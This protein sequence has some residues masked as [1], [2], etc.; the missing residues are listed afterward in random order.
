[1]PERTTS[2]A[3]LKKYTDPRALLRS[4]IIENKISIVDEKIF[5]NNDTYSFFVT[6]EENIDYTS[7]I[8]YKY[9][10]IG[11]RT[12]LGVYFCDR[13][14][15]GICV[16]KLHKNTDGKTFCEQVRPWYHTKHP[17]T[18]H[19]HFERRPRV[20]KNERR[21]RKYLRRVRRNPSILTKQVGKIEL[22]GYQKCSDKCGNKPTYV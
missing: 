11:N 1:M 6:P 10:L 18:L 8:E 12:R 17:F 2:F 22:I 15:G 7:C 5:K 21:M 3:P 13:S 20:F 4:Q 14:E 9:S 19:F 16:M